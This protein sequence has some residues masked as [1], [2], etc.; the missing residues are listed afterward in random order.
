MTGAPQ[1]GAARPS[2]VGGAFGRLSRARSGERLT[3]GLPIAVVALAAGAASLW[4]LLSWPSAATVDA[5]AYAAW[6]QAL[7]RAERPLFELGATTPKPLAAVLGTLV[8]PLPPER[9]FPVVVALAAAVLAAALFAAAFREGGAVAACVAVVALGF[10]VRLPAHVAFGLVDVVVAALVMAGV[11]LRGPWRIGAFV[12][13]GLLRPEAWVLAAIAGFTET[14]GSLARRAGVAVAAGAA[15]PVL[16]LL[17]DLVLTGDP[18]ASLHWHFDRLGARGGEGLAWV[19][20]PGELWT[21]LGSA[22]G[23]VVVIGGLLGLGVHYVRARRGGN[24]DWMPLAVILVWPLLIALQAGYGTNMRTRY[25][26][27]VAAVLALGCGL[28]V[29]ALLTSKRPWATWGAVAVAAGALVVVALSADIPEGMQESIARNEA[30]AATRP[31]LESVQD[32]GRVGVTRSS[33]FRGLI[34]QLAASSRRSLKEYGIYRRDGEFAAVLHF[35]PRF[36]SAEPP[37]PPWPRQASPLG[38]LAVAPGCDALD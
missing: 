27:P 15:G 6:G 37:L 32:C 7:A 31:T 38:P 33:A 20:V 19:D 26:L 34:P 12:L 30:V 10:G 36:S 23:T 2:W 22:G 35:A 17:S 11:A 16:W 25:L 8:A 28:L 18:L 29:A 3:L 24:V 21:R 13:A 4:R 1:P 9:A 14:A 5:W